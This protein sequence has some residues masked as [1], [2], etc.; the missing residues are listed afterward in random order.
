MLFRS[1]LIA[2]V[3]VAL[4]APSVNS[5]VAANGASEE[6]GSA[7]W[8]AMRAQI[9]SQV[10]MGSAPSFADVDAK[11][12]KAGLSETDNGWHMAPEILVD[13]LDHD[14]F[15]SCFMTMQAPDSDAMIG[16]I[17]DRLMQDHGAAFSGPNTGLSAVAPFQ[18]GDQEVVSILEP[19]V[20][21]D[22][23]WLAARVSVFGPCQTG[24]IQG[25][26]SE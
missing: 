1:T 12:A 20:F 25:E 7:A 26:G 17:H 9:F 19:R 21:N 3:T 15:C 13:V 8:L 16:T 2:L 5:A 10:C 24:V 23:N 4:H 6:K 18:F 11:A 22:E 14:G